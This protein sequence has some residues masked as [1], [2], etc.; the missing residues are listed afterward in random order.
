MAESEL[1]RPAPNHTDRSTRLA[2]F[3]LLAVLAGA[4]FVALGLLNLALPFVADRLPV[5]DGTAVDLPTAIMGALVYLA[6]G[7]VLISTGIGSYRK[8]RW[9]RPVML[10][11]AWTWLIAG[12]L[13]MVLIAVAL[14]DLMILATADL[15][16]V[17]LE[18]ALMVKLFV[19]G[20][21]AIGGVV[22]PLLFVWA[23]QDRDVGWT[24]ARHDP[25]PTW[26]DR[27]PLPVLA[28]SLGLGFAAV[29]C[30][31]LAMRPVVPLFGIL[32]G[33]WSAA[34]LILGGAVVAG[35][36]ARSTYR[37]ESAGWWATTVLLVVVGASIALTF[38]R[39]PP[40]EYYRQL[41]Y[42]EEQ[43]MLLERSSLG[44]PSLVVW[45]TVV[46]TLLSVA[47]MIAVRRFF[48]PHARS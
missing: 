12:A 6:I 34:L 14:N 17:P 8:K 27:C 43:L 47:Y 13:G 15:E 48:A 32:V 21:A 44:H 5:A 36:L 31:P 39:V 9:V 20:V 26:T 18:V 1:Q 2:L 23:Y 24:C 35:L 22:L 28:L 46:L 3:G 40:V 33:G 42:P 45:S 10:V 41:G 11:V 16:H 7:G 37:L 30:V 4:G 38:L 25:G 19:L 29:L